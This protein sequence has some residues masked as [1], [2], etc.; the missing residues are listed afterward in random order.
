ML[1]DDIEEEEEDKEEEEEDI[2]LV[3]EIEEED[4][5]DKM[6]RLACAIQQLEDYCKELPILG[7]NSAS[8]DINFIRSHWFEVLSEFG[9][10]T[11]FAAFIVF[12]VSMHPDQSL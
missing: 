5:I 4:E 8:Y 11:T 9:E 10:T 6:K 1:L 12:Q 3:E 7:L 2:D